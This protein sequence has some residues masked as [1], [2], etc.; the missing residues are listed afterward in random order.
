MYYDDG[1][2]DRANDKDEL[3]KSF[4]DAIAVVRGWLEWWQKQAIIGTHVYLDGGGAAILARLS[5]PP[6]LRSIGSTSL[7]RIPVQDVID[8][9]DGS[10]TDP[11]A[12]RFPIEV[13]GG[14]LEI[15]ARGET[16][17]ETIDLPVYCR[18]TATHI[19]L[20]LISGSLVARDDIMTQFVALRFL[21]CREPIG[22]D[23]LSRVLEEGGYTGFTI[24]WGLA[25]LAFAFHDLTPRRVAAVYRS[26]F[27]H[28]TIA[29]LPEKLKNVFRRLEQMHQALLVEL[30]DRYHT[31]R[32]AVQRAKGKP[33]HRQELRQAWEDLRYLIGILDQAYPGLEFPELGEARSIL[34][35]KSR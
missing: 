26:N 18:I 35:E 5:A 22:S 17:A 21:I 28:P 30:L 6:R 27:Q 34:S 12:P 15:P 9:S 8:L 24:A 2:P 16:S 10:K 29:T 23:V 7:L 11:L 19:D 14:I 32:R 1:A 4:D 33:Q 25:A 13:P 3:V 20:A 31:L